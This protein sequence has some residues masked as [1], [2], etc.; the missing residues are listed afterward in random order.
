[1][2]GVREH[3]PAGGRK[4]GPCS[5]LAH[6]AQR[7]GTRLRRQAQ[8][9]RLL[10]LAWQFPRPA[11][12]AVFCADPRH[13][14]IALA[15]RDQMPVVRNIALC[16][17]TASHGSRASRHH[18]PERQP[19]VS[20]TAHLPQFIFA[21]PARAPRSKVHPRGVGGGRGDA[22]VHR[23]QAYP[24]GAGKRRPSEI[25]C[26]R[27]VVQRPESATHARRQAPKVS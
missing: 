6:N 16:S 3:S 14:R 7:G 9:E 20:K 15:L 23:V 27:L 12:S 8:I 26:Y 13:F 25:G 4:A 19:K 11:T 22:T 24:R 10:V 2:A 1:M 21:E 5:C 17:I 18:G